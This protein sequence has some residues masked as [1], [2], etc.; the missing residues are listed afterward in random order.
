LIAPTQALFI[1]TH[2]RLLLIVAQTYQINPSAQ[3]QF[4]SFSMTFMLRTWVRHLLALFN[5]IPA[6]PK[7]Q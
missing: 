3:P 1:F 5:S 6:D 2:V 7:P 4:Y